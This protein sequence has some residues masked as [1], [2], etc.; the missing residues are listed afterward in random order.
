MNVK[1]AFMILGGVLFPTSSIAQYGLNV[2]FVKQAFR[3]ALPPAAECTMYLS[4]P[5]C[6]MK[7]EAGELDANQEM[8]GPATIELRFR[9]ESDQLRPLHQ[10]LLNFPVSFGF[11]VEQVAACLKD[12]VDKWDAYFS[13][14]TTVLNN[15]SNQTNKRFEL[16]CE[17]SVY[18]Q[19]RVEE[20][21]RL[22]VLIFENNRF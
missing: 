8:G 4:R 7:N 3:L 9:K 13:R 15:S 10:A 1:I 2:E 19:H 22:A 18:N 12:T 20:Y 6:K 16:R 5:S 11:T 21:K 17:Y 14:K